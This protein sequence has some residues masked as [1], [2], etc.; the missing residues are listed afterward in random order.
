MWFP[1]IF[2]NDDLLVIAA[3]PLIIVICEMLFAPVFDSEESEDEND[4]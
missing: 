2:G 3:I 4:L 1:I